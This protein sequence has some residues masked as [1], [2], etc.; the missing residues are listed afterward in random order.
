MPRYRG[1]ATSTM[2][3]KKLSPSMPALNPPI[4]AP[5]SQQHNQRAK[6]A[7]AI[8]S[9]ARHGR[10]TTILRLPL[11]LRR[12]EGTGKGTEVACARHHNRR[13][14]KNRT[15]LSQPAPVAVPWR[16]TLPRPTIPT[17]CCQIDLKTRQ[18]R[19]GCEHG[20]VKTKQAKPA[21]HP[22][23]C[24]QKNHPLSLVLVL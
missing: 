2:A 22:L 24:H 1:R 8:M 6:A 7:P 18:A 9:R 11:L 14:Q 12:R 21:T 23:L 17:Y 20:S 16:T 4:P 19:T 10:R 3:T 5:R 13:T 15:H